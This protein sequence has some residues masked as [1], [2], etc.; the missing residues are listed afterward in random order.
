MTF[1]Q[2]MSAAKNGS[3]VKRSSWTDKTVTYDEVKN[4]FNEHIISTINSRFTSNEDDMS[5][6]DWQTV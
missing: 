1:E 3:T 5:A 4:V 6:T 2:A